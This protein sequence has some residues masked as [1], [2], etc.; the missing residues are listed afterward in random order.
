MALSDRFVKYLSIIGMITFPVIPIYA[1]PA[2]PAMSSHMTHKY[3]DLRPKLSRMKWREGS[4]VF[5][6]DRAIKLV[7]EVK[8]GKVVKI[9]PVNISGGVI[10]VSR[11]SG[12]GRRPCI[13]CYNLDKVLES[14]CI[15]VPCWMVPIL[16]PILNPRTT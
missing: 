5:Y 1:G 4:N 16:G 10:H 3:I 8:G 6:S 15:E 7:A 11:Q 2:K 9:T 13:I 14:N 12:T